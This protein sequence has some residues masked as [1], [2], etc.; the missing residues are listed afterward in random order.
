MRQCTTPEQTARLIELGFEKPRVFAWYVK[1]IRK[2]VVCKEYSIGELIAMLPESASQRLRYVAT[3]RAWIVDVDVLGKQG[4]C[5][6]G[7]YYK[8]LIDALYAMILKLKEAGVI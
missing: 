8:E 3:K 4:R 5:H 2:E 6:R 7:A 1:A